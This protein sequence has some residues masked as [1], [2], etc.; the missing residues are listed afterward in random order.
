M[1]RQGRWRRHRNPVANCDAVGD[2]DP[3]TA[4]HFA[5]TGRRSPHALSADSV[6]HRPFGARAA[7][8]PRGCGGIR[9]TCERGMRRGRAVSRPARKMVAVQHAAR[10]ARPGPPAGAL[11]LATGPPPH[12]GVRS[13]GKESRV[14]RSPGVASRSARPSDLLAGGPGSRSSPAVPRLLGAGL[15]FL[16][17]RPSRPCGIRPTRCGPRRSRRRRP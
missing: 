12:G 13:S 5:P 3:S 9:R 14:R 2:D 7:S 4:G 16:T 11:G 8:K 10:G 15:R 17:P 6:R 1:V